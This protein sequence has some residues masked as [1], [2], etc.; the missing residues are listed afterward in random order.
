ML[1]RNA[2]LVFYEQFPSEPTKE[3][4]EDIHTLL[5]IEKKRQFLTRKV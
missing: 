3:L 4:K 1:L 5:R 2:A